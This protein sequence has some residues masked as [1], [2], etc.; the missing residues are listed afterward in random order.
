MNLI[1]KAF[2]E[3]SPTHHFLSFF[4]WRP[5]STYLLLEE[6]DLSLK[7]KYDNKKLLLLSVEPYLC[8]KNLICCFESLWTCLTTFTSND[9]INVSLLLPTYHMQK[10]NFLTQLFLEMKL[11]YYLLSLWACSGLSTP[12]WTSQLSFGAFLDL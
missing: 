11:T 9:W 4:P 1:D 12:T 10:T 3:K 5:F 2:L 8:V 7:T 6:G